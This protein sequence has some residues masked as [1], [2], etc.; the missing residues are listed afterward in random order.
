M[1][2]TWNFVLDLWQSLELATVG[3]LDA[4]S[5]VK[6]FGL[7]SDCLLIYRCSESVSCC[8]FLTLIGKA[9][10][11][12]SLDVV[13]LLEKG[14]WLAHVKTVLRF[15][16]SWVRIHWEL[17]KLRLQKKM[18]LMAWHNEHEREVQCCFVVSKWLSTNSLSCFHTEVCRLVEGLRPI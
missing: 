11:F 16:P 17:S 10:F 7:L 1:H 14:K 15:L 3:L 8:T 6:A 5:F 9:I 13:T 2:T 4:C 18:G 12:S